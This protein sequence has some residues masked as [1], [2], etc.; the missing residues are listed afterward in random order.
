VDNRYM[1][2]RDMLRVGVGSDIPPFS[3]RTTSKGTHVSGG[4]GCATMRGDAGCTC[5][6][7]VWVS[8]RPVCCVQWVR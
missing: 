4:R 3:T 6:L 8:W 2:H 5:A 7:L 1:R